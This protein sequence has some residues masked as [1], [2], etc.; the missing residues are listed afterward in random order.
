[1][2]SFVTAQS[3][4]LRGVV[5]DES[6]AVVPGATVV[7]T[8]HTGVANTVMTASDGSYSFLALAGD[9]TVQASAPDLK[10]GPVNVTVRQG[11]QV[12]DL[13]LKVTLAAQQVTVEERGV[14]VT[15]EPANNV[16][17]TVLGGTDLEALSDNPDD[18][19]ADLIAI[20]GPGAGP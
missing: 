1:F 15:P 8:P 6:G 17:A 2:S 4:T 5:T 18:L 10:S 13:Q 16:S 12:L 11:L 9:Y 3:G 19:I 20:A 14:T 7:V